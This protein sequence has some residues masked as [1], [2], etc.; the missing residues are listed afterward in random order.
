MKEEFKSIQELTGKLDEEFEKLKKDISKKQEQNLGK[1]KQISKM[2][3]ITEGINQDHF[4][5]FFEEPYV[6]LP[7]TKKE[8]WYI[9]VPKFIRMNLGWLDHTTTTYNVFKVNKFMKW[10]GNLPHD[11]E[12]KFKFASQ[13]P[14]KVFDGVLLTGQEHQ[15]EAWE[16]YR[17]M[18]QNR[19]GTDRI[20]VKKNY[21]FKLL[22]SIINDGILPFIPQ[23][24][25]TDD[26]RSSYEPQIK[27]RDYQID[28]WEKFKETGAVGIYWA[29]SAGKTFFGIYA[30]S[31][32]KGWKLIVVPTLTLKEQWEQRIKQ[33]APEY[34]KEFIVMTYQSF[35]NIQ[36]IMKEKEITQFAL[37]E[38]DECQHLP[39]N[40]F[41]RLAT[42]PTKYRMGLSA[43]PYREDGR[44]DYIFALTGYPIGLSWDNLI[45]LGILQVPDI[46]VYLVT[47]RMDKEK[48]LKELLK[49]PK[50]T[51][52]FCD[53]IDWGKRLS[54][55]LEI[56]FVYGDTKERLK[57]IKEAQECIVSRVGDEG[58]SLPELQRV[59][60]I[61]FLYGSRR[62]EGQRLGRLFHGEEKG[63]HII[64]MTEQEF[65]DHE[66]R[67]Y[68]ITEKGFKMEIIR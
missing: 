66:K 52:I 28:G 12:M 6:V 3:Q 44:T 20:K 34:E 54:K 68:A 48:K 32:I 55:E 45:E 8:E 40:T 59:I 36:K 19:M 5:G 62:Q 30:G 22:A 37:I 9:A 17:P 18:L 42:I 51:L 27:L 57:I 47:G 53:S 33:L 58:L 1:L 49:D 13:M 46:R 14:L 41:S 11:I 15:A 21:E 10:M 56:P 38:F 4:K 63:E 60:E 65:Q 25:A 26:L 31:K 7:G 29:Y 23:P 2:S 64:I 24:V 16:R 39:A 50:K 67:L 35:K 43:T 61:D